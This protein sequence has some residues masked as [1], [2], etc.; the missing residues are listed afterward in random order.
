MY[1]SHGF[2]IIVWLLLIIFCIS[3]MAS[4]FRYAS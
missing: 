1:D 3:I 4:I 2:L